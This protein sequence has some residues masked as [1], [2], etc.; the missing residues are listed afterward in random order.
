V[1][2]QFDNE[3]ENIEI[4]GPGDH[5][6][7]FLKVSDVGNLINHSVCCDFPVTAK[8]FQWNFEGFKT[9]LPLL[10]L[11]IRTCKVEEFNI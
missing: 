9:S 11:E 5:S 10:A 8:N 6:V 3:G 1:A 2:I 7:V 4:T